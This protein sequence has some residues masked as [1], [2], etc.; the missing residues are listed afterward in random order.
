[1]PA[2]LTR[3]VEAAELLPGV[4]DQLDDVVLV[5]DVALEPVHA[6]RAV[7][8]GVESTGDSLVGDVAE[9]DL[10]ARAGE[11]EGELPAHAGTTARDENLG[12]RD[13]HGLLLGGSRL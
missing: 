13:V 11:F 4:A 12:R 7:L 5:G 3:A 1:M 9:R 6:A 2:L 8:R 10:C